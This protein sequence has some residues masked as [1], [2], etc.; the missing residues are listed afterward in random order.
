MT[1]QNF[2]QHHKIVKNESQ[3]ISRR[4]SIFGY[5]S[6]AIGATFRPMTANAAETNGTQLP[7][8]AQA[9]EKEKQI[10]SQAL[11]KIPEVEKSVTPQSIEYLRSSQ[12]IGVLQEYARR[13]GPNAVVDDK[14]LAKIEKDL[15]QNV[16][17][18]GDMRAQ[19]MIFS[20]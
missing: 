12:K 18:A 17:K 10:A 14:L 2:G 19:I 7:T 4:N 16:P 5:M 11:S 3:P 15:K 20:P 1:E 6:L 8:I 9:L 13:K